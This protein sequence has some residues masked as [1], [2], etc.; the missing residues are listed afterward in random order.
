MLASTEIHVRLSSLNLLRNIACCAVITLHT[1]AEFIYA[2]DAIPHLQWW[3]FNILDSATRWAVPVFVMISGATNLAPGRQEGYPRRLSR[4]LFLTIFWSCAYYCFRI[5]YY[6]EEASPRKLAQKFFYGDIIYHLYFL[7]ILAGLYALNPV[8]SAAINALSRRAA[9]LAS[10]GVLT[11][12]WLVFSLTSPRQNLITWFIPYIGYYWL[13]Y[14][15][16]SQPI[17][18]RTPGAILLFCIALIA[19][20]TERLVREYG[21]NSGNALY[22]YSYFVPTTVIATLCVFS[23]ATD[24]SAIRP[25]KMARYFSSLTLGIFLVHPAILILMQ[26]ISIS[27]NALVRGAAILSATFILSVLSCAILSATPLLGKTIR[28]YARPVNPY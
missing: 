14:L 24:Y 20:I 9:L 1:S 26:N 7:Y 5:F 27:D 11:A 10:F 8:L 13:G 23:I 6:G 15:C 3:I 18:I 2:Y 28:P 25:S 12:A 19:V 22:M 17:R 4:V 16:A 21:I